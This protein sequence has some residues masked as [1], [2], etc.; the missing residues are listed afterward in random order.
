MNNR[1]MFLNINY[2]PEFPV[3]GS[4][5]HL[6]KRSIMHYEEFHKI[7]GKSMGF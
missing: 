6:F 3:T 2:E 1:T 5:K 4:F 7:A